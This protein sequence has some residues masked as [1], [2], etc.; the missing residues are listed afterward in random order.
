[1]VDAA[2]S[3]GKSV[4]RRLGARVLVLLGQALNAVAIGFVVLAE[5]LR[6]TTEQPFSAWFPV[7]FFVIVPAMLAI[8]PWYFA[9]RGGQ[10][11]PPLEA[12][13]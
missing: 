3:A 12:K 11:V 8:L 5:V 10:L 1:M 6:S 4:G 13:G 9:R 2:L 7:A